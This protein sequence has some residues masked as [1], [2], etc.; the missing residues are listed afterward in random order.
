MGC[1]EGTGGNRGDAETV[2]TQRVQP[3]AHKEERQRGTCNAG[4]EGTQKERWSLAGETVLLKL[5]CCI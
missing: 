5:G 2:R 1:L 4:A 3:S